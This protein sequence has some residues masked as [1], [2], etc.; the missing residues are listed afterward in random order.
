[1]YEAYMVPVGKR[2]LVVMGALRPG[3]FF[4]SS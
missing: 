3:H 4:E 2:R 1:M